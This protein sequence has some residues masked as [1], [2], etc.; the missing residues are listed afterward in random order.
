VDHAHNDWLEWTAEGGAPMLLLLAAAAVAAL[1]RA[2]RNPWGLGIYAVFLHSS[3]EF[4][5]Q[6]PAIAFLQFTLLGALFY[7][8][9]P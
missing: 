4:P 8:K 3:V 5:L 1:P 9:D 2:I 7:R 6:I